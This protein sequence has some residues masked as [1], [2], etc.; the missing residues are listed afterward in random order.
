MAQYLHRHHPGL[1]SATRR[2]LF[3]PLEAEMYRRELRDRVCMIAE[4]HRMRER[5]KIAW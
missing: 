3:D 1:I 2:I 5:L 4:S